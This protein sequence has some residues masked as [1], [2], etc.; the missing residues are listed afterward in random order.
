LFDEGLDSGAQA[1][2]GHLSG[3][4]GGQAVFQDKR[5]IEILYLQKPFRGLLQSPLRN[6]SHN[7]T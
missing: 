5:G 1:A 3:H 4:H 2:D 6:Q 7:L